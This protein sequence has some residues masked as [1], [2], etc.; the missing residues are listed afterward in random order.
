MGNRERTRSR[1]LFTLLLLN[2]SRLLETKKRK[3]PVEGR[4]GEELVGVN[5]KIVVL[6]TTRIAPREGHLD[7]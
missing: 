7:R 3:V 5:A 2:L 1:V 4:G 6:Q